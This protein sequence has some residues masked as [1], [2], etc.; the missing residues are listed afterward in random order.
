MNKMAKRIGKNQLLK[1]S[2]I[3]LKSWFTYEASILGSFAACMATYALYVLVIFILNNYYDELLTPMDVVK[4][5]FKVWSRFDW[6]NNI[7][8]IYGPVSVSNFYEKLRDC[9]FDVERLALLERSLS[10]DFSGKKLLVG[11]EEIQKMSLMFAGVRL[12]DPSTYHLANKKTF[13]TKFLNI[14][15]PTF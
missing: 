13:N 7:V 14:I 12:S 9:Q 4:K 2:I 5:F 3:L 1:K 15:D 11:P 10:K 6:D 8:T